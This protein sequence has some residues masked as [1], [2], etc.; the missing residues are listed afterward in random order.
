MINLPYAIC[1]YFAIIFAG[2]YI[3]IDILIDKYKEYKYKKLK[4]K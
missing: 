4:Q 2:I 3:L 1:V